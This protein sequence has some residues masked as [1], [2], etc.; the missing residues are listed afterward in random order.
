[1]DGA[2]SAPV[3]PASTVRRPTALL[4]LSTLFPP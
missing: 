2:A 3:N 1:M 4:E